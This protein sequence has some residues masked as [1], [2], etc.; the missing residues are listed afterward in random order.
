MSKRENQIVEEIR[1]IVEDIESAS[2]GD[3]D[4]WKDAWSELQEVA[5]HIPPSMSGVRNVSG[6]CE[7]GLGFLAKNSA[8]GFLS[9]VEAISEGLIASVECLSGDPNGDAFLKKAG[10][11]LE[12]ALK[13]LPERGDAADAMERLD[14]E[15]WAPNGAEAVSINDAAALLIQME[16]DDLAEMP[17]L[18]DLL[19]ALTENGFYSESA[20]KAIS[21][22]AL[23]AEVLADA[24]ACDVDAGIAEIGRLVEYAMNA[25]VENGPEFRETA[26]DSKDH[27]SGDD[28]MEEAEPL[29]DPALETPARASG[30]NR[31][32]L[33]LPEDADR[34]LL[35]EFINESG[36]LIE[37]AEE[38]L[39]ALET[40]PED[41]ES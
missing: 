18:R 6:L 23:R 9:L 33:S 16:S 21:E 32:L 15:Q 41:M 17:R 40:D 35:A 19:H 5:G 3:I 20:R 38:A 22:A 1:K 39:L 2:L 8:K 31:E 25:M 11:M 7:E 10:Q 30:G 36:D 12:D 24:D 14:Q 27:A 37:A 29:S 34:D 26:P 4:A 28:G 13:E